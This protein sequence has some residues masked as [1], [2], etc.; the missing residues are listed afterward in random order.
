MTRITYHIV[1][2]DGGWAYKLGDV[3]SEPFRT[4]Q[5]AMD[6][7]RRAAFEQGLPDAKSVSISWEDENGTW[8]DE[9]S[10]GDDRPDAEVDPS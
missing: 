10:K 5:E 2:H 1:Q 6:A 9:V 4:R 7:A 3:F 8:H